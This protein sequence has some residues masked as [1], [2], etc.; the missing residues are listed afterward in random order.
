MPRRLRQIRASRVTAWAWPCFQ[1]TTKPGGA[2]SGRAA[3]LAHS[4]MMQQAKGLANLCTS[5]HSLRDPSSTFKL[6]ASCVLGHGSRGAAA[7]TH[8][9]AAA[10]C[11]P[12]AVQL[13]PWLCPDSCIHGHGRLAILRLLPHKQP[14]CFTWWDAAAGVLTGVNQPQPR[15]QAVHNTSH[16]IIVEYQQA[17]FRREDAGRRLR[18][19]GREGSRQAAPD[20][21]HEHPVPQESELR[22]SSQVLT[23][24]QAAAA[25]PISSCGWSNGA[26]ALLSSRSIIIIT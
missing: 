21:R 8:K 3:A 14:A 17:G 12:T 26:G 5:S 19:R 6:T 4:S 10:Q 16:G 24:P 22:A 15:L 2:N 25:L 23:A 13:R 1:E 7:C 9:R 11:G 18:T 20:T